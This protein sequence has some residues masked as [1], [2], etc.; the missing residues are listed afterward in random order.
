VGKLV[1]QPYQR[2]YFNICKIF[3]KENAFSAWGG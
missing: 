2:W 1:F 3:C